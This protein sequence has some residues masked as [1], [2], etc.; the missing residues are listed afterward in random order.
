[1]AKILR[2]EKKPAYKVTTIKNRASLG[3]SP[4]AARLPKYMQI[5]KRG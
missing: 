2:K 4:I 1:M 3:N 5:T